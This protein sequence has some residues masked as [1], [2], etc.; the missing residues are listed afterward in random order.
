MEKTILILDLDGVLITT[1]SWKA[2]EIAPDGYSV[3]NKKCVD[4]LNNLLSKSAFD[5]WLSSTRRTVK[6]LE[7]FNTIFENRNIKEPI[8]GF[9]PEYENCK[10]RADEVVR[11][12]EEFEILNFII[13]DDDKSLNGIKENYKK[14]LVLTELQKGFDNEKLKIA[15][16]KI[17]K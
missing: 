1:P 16:E 7:E 14:Q 13:L 8:I 11:F 10:S 5:I 3:F 17:K 15:I 2:D 12:I 9:L 4:N 6:S